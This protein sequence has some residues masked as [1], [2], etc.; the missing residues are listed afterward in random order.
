MQLSCTFFDLLQSIREA[1][2]QF[3]ICPR[4]SII[5]HLHKTGPLYWVNLLIL[6][7]AIVGA[8]AAQSGSASSPPNIIAN[9]VAMPPHILDA[10]LVGTPQSDVRI[11]INFSGNAPDFDS[12]ITASI[13]GFLSKLQSVAEVMGPS[14]HRQRWQPRLLNP[15]SAVYNST[16]IAVKAE[17]GC[18]QVT[19]PTEGMTPGE[20]NDFVSWLRVESVV[21]RSR[22]TPEAAWELSEDIK[23]E[24]WQANNRRFTAEGAE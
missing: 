12:E 6:E 19:I 22:L 10:F 15:A 18:L 24:W 1:F 20:V 13:K 21:R 14:Q 11:R 9:T 16:M 5:G 23:S 8:A 4:P 2:A 3:L 7:T 17:N